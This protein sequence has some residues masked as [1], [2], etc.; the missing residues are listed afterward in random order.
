MVVGMVTVRV[1]GVR[2]RLSGTRVVGGRAVRSA[3][4]MRPDT[5]TPDTLTFRCTS[6]L[7]TASL[8]YTPPTP[9]A[10]AEANAGPL[11]MSTAR[12]WPESGLLGAPASTPSTL[13]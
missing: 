12:G 10:T 8:Q 13:T 5:L 4:V 11:E 6:R 2:V 9:P 1:S 3:I 7:T